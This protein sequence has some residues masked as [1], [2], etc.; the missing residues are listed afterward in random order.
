[1]LHLVG[2]TRTEI[3]PNLG[4]RGCVEP[5]RTIVEIPPRSTCT[6]ASL[7]PCVLY[8]VACGY[9]RCTY[10]ENWGKI[11]VF[12]SDDYLWALHNLHLQF[13]TKKYAVI[14]DCFPIV[15]YN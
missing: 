10:K 12:R 9:V 7:A 11:L 6:L 4:W 15:M 14:E 2:S 8:F 5:R 3:L 1:M 13:F